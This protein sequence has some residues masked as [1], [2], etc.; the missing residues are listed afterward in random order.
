[1]TIEA[2]FV[3]SL[4]AA[5]AL[6]STE[7][8]FNVLC[9]PAFTRTSQPEEVNYGILSV[10]TPYSTMNAIQFTD[11]NGCGKVPNYIC[12]INGVACPIW[13]T[14]NASKKMS[15]NTNLLANVGRYTVTIE[16]NYIDS[17][18]VTVALPPTEWIL[19]VQC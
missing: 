16:A 8:V 4:G 11:S 5:V 10:S 6:P 19:N 17:L 12:K 1:M 14:I 18:G 13:I 9:Q 3:D 15:I 2:Y 7:W